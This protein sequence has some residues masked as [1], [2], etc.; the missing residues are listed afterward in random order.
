MQTTRIEQP[1]GPAAAERGSTLI[2]LLIMMATAVVVLAATLSGVVQHSRQRRSN[3]EMSLAMTACRNTLE[4]LRSVEFATLPTLDGHGFDVPA[5][6][7]SPGGLTPVEG[8][9]DG[10]PGLITIT[11][12][13]T[14]GTSCLYR[15]EASV[16]W[17]G[18]NPSGRF[19][20]TTLFSERK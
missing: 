18:I 16:R 8:D 9:P 6:D 10:L 13:E 20:L 3:A 14:D 2:E 7:G 1:T 15:V 5:L 4:Q 17:Q 12:E 19:A 11:V